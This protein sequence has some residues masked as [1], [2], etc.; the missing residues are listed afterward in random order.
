MEKILEIWKDIPSYEGVYQISNL[1]RVKS[2]NYLRMG[3]ESIRKPTLNKGYLLVSLYKNNKQKMWSVHRLVAI[4]FIENPEN[5]EQ[6][7]HKNG[8]RNDN[9][10]ENLEWSTVSENNRHSYEILGR[11]APSLGVFG[12]DNPSSKA[13]LQFSKNGEFIKEWPSQRD[14]TRELNICYKNISAC[15]LNKPRFNSAGGYVWKFKEE[16]VCI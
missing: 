14:V 7:N 3:F 1:G 8:V 16:E 2:L 6:V 5:K 4:S 11:K 15:C 10:L 12:K 13:I 9:R